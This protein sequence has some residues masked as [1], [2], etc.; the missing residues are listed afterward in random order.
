MAKADVIEQALK[1]LA[2]AL[3]NHE[4][5]E[6]ALTEVGRDELP[7]SVLLLRRSHAD[8]SKAA[9]A[10]SRVVREHAIPYLADFDRVANGG[11]G[12]VAPMVTKVVAGQST[13][14]RA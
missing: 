10:L 4:I 9:Y 5:A 6:G 7:F 2:E 8:V 14:S 13:P 3:F 11:M 12:A 1:G